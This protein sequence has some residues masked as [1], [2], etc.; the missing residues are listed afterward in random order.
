MLLHGAVGS[1]NDIEN[2]GQVSSNQ[3]DI[4]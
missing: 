3:H 2:F 4:F 1:F